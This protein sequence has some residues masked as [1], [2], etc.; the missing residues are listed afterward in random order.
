M[1]KA[2]KLVVVVFQKSGRLIYMHK[3]LFIFHVMYIV[4]MF[5]LLIINIII[6]SE[7]SS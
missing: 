3:T 4:L 5:V 1:S 6:K 2:K 7:S